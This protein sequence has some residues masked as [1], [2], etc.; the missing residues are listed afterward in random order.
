MSNGE[1]I[2]SDYSADDGATILS[3]VYTNNGYTTF[4]THGTGNG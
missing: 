2:E 3:L 1:T 4:Y